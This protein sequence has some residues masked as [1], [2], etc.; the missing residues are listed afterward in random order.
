MAF[1]VGPDYTLIPGSVSGLF[2]GH[3]YRFTVTGWTGG[4]Q[5]AVSWG[6][7][8]CNV[9]CQYWQSLTP[10]GNGGG[11]IDSVATSSVAYLAGSH[12][13]DHL[14][15]TGWTYQ[16]LDGPSPPP[17]TPPS[18][19]PVVVVST[20]AFDVGPDY[21]VIPGLATDLIVGHHYR[22]TVNDWNG[23]GRLA[24]SW[25][26]N[27]CN[28]SCD[29]WNVMTPDG[30]GGGYWDSVATATSAGLAGSH[31]GIRLTGS[32]WTYQ[33]LDAFSADTSGTYSGGGVWH[34]LAVAFTSIAAG[35]PV[36]IAYD[37]WVGSD[38]NGYHKV[39]NYQLVNATGTVL[40]SGSQ[41]SGG[42]SS[43]G[44]SLEF[45]TY[46][47][48]YSA[49]NSN[50][51]YLFEVSVSS[52]CD[53]QASP[54]AMLTAVAPPDPFAADT[55]GTYS[56]SGVWHTLAVAPTTIAEG[57]AVDISYDLWVSS[58]CNGHDKVFSYQLVDSTGTVLASGVQR[59]GSDTSS[60]HDLE[61][62]APPTLYTSARSN[63]SYRI[64][65][66]VGSPC[67]WYA[68][69]AAAL[70]AAAINGAGPVDPN[71]TYSGSGAWHTIAAATVSD[72]LGTSISGSFEGWVSSDCR[73][74]HKIFDWVVLDTLGYVL[75]SGRQE[76]GSDT[77]SGHN[78]YFSGTF[79]QTTP[80]GT[81]RYAL[82]LRI[83]S[84][85]DFEASPLPSISVP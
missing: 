12:I 59:V 65:V 24:V 76:S 81:D 70:T 75:A 32:G 35:D 2:I 69:P 49:A 79:G 62:A 45:L 1:D 16:D 28:V 26:G 52:P 43:S 27:N 29:A 41:E 44:H 64:Q 47:T 80:I 71:G 73:D 51:I 50:D 55:S 15:G 30:S 67:Y 34:T 13:S 72:P 18:A 63:D 33:D 3:H 46:P 22:F 83:S 85:C 42:D 23:G 39:F 9:S 58:D 40:T 21:T 36:E 77:A 17:V 6:G 48:Q 84:S 82:L 78:L 57:A 8:S 74:Q 60:G 20:T 54:A 38:C 56:G 11:Y 66:S 31:I 68:S 4:G 37:A 61:L 5:L 25:G 7:N 14:A 19:G 10:D 53:F